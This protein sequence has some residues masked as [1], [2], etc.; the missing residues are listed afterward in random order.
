MTRIAKSG[1]ID[2]ASV[3]LTVAEGIL[4]QMG[5]KNPNV[6]LVSKLA[7]TLGGLISKDS[8]PKEG[9]TLPMG[10]ALFGAK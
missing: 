6:L 5:W 4:K 9:Q 2:E 3:G 1:E 8:G 7:Q 10:K